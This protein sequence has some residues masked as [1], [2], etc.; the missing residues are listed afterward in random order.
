MLAVGTKE[1]FII[2]SFFE[3]IERFENQGFVISEENLC[4]VSHAL[5]EAHIGEF[6]TSR[7]PPSLQTPGPL[8]KDTI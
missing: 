7:R 3:R 1:Y 5:K 4:V 8:T 2:Q 6:T